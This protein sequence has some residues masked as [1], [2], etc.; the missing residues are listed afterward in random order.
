LSKKG[1]PA[2][3]PSSLIANAMKGGRYAE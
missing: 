2:G 3:A 1:A